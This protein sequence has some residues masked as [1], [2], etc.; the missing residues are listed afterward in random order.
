MN[1]NKVSDEEIWDKKLLSESS[2]CI[3]LSEVIDDTQRISDDY[4]FMDVAFDDDFQGLLDA[5]PSPDLE[6]NDRIKSTHESLTKELG[7]SKRTQESECLS[8]SKKRRSIQ[9][10]SSTSESLDSDAFGSPL[11]HNSISSEDMRDIE[12][13]YKYALHHLALSMRRSEVTRNEILRFRKEAEARA[14][15]ELAEYRT[16]S[17]AEYFLQ[18]YRSTLTVGLDQSR[19]MLQTMICKGNL[20]TM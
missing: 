6:D 14:Q 12:D 9:G 2:D 10:I 3:M 20:Y 8:P 4:F 7:R 11:I 17:N 18:G 19:Q 1:L 5:C 16:L 15:L 13:Q